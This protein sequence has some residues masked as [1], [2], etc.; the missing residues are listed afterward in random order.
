MINLNLTKTI[1]T[2]TEYVLEQP[3]YQADK[4]PKDGL[5]FPN[6]F[7]TAAPYNVVGKK[8]VQDFSQLTYTQLF[9]ERSDISRAEI[10]A[11]KDYILTKNELKV[12]SERFFIRWYV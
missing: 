10:D 9:D 12:A 8:G 1:Q 4:S 2:K 11:T 7:V 5:I 6:K 3:Q